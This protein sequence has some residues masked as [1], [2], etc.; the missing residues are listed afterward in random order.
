MGPSS[1]VTALRLR[2]KT[3]TPAPESESDASCH[4]GLF[5]YNV[6][7]NSVFKPVAPLSPICATR[8]CNDPGREPKS[9]VCAAAE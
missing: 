6:M 8:M 4:S 2:E 7:V 1:S 3:R 9:V 5:D